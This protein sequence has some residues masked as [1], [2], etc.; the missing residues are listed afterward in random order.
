MRVEFRVD[1]LAMKLNIQA[2]QLNI[3]RSFTVE[4]G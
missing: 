3:T 4:P 1:I 2:Q